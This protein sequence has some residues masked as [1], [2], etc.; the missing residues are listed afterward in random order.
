MG[1]KFI[2]VKEAANVYTVGKDFCLE[3]AGKAVLRV[4]ALGLY[5]AEINGK[6]VGDAYLTPGWTCYH[7]MLQVQEYDVTDLLQK[8]ENNISF[9][10]AEGWYKG[11]LVYADK[12]NIYGDKT[13]V[14]AQLIV[15]GKTVVVTDE[16]FVA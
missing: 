5:K 9:T 4:T 11:R 8:G 3:H 16:S 13:A 10:V 7:K 15:D 14:W 6:K 2:G 1:I 12:M